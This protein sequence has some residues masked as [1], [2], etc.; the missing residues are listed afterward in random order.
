MLIL[1][2]FKTPYQSSFRS[3]NWG[4]GD[5]QFSWSEEKTKRRQRLIHSNYSIWNFMM[6]QMNITAPENEPI[7]L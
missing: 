2:Y 1:K 4:K 6:Y 3:P 7:K 5:I